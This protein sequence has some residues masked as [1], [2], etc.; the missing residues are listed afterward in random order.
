MKTILHV[1]DDPLIAHIYGTALKRAGFQVE[2]AEDGVLAAKMLFKSRPDLVVLDL[3]IPKLTGK[4]VIKYIRSTPALQT[5]PVVIL[6]SASIADLGVEA[7]ALGVESVLYKSQCTPAILISVVNS[8]L[9]DTPISPDQS[10]S[11]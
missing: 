6:S 7:A 9:N 10:P 4:D 5:L 3:M 1:E 2:V 11:A 8:L